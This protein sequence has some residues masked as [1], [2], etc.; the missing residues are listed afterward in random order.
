MKIISIVNSVYRR[1]IFIYEITICIN[2]DSR[3]MYTRYVYTYEK[4]YSDSDEIK[5][6]IP[7]SCILS[8]SILL[9]L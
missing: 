1:I 4:V 6:A 9:L 2:L 7:I 5:I 8:R 3:M